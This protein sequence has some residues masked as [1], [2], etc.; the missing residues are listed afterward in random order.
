MGRHT[1]LLHALAKA[2]SLAHL[3]MKEN[4]IRRRIRFSYVSLDL[5]GYPTGS[6]NEGIKRKG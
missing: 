3:G 1:V 4:K 2:W 5:E 6:M